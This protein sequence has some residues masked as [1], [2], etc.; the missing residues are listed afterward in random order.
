MNTHPKDKPHSSFHSWE[1]KLSRNIS[2]NDK[3]KVGWD[4]AHVP[5][6]VPIAHHCFFAVPGIGYAPFTVRMYELQKRA[7]I[8]SQCRLRVYPILKNNKKETGSPQISE[9][10]TPAPMLQK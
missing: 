1:C 5:L 7:Y 3:C 6:K 9:E 2:K 8:Q 4:E 10:A